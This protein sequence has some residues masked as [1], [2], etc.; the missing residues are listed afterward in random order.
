MQHFFWSFVIIKDKRETILGTL[1]NLLE[2]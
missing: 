2:L 1:L